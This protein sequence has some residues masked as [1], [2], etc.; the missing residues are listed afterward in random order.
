MFKRKLYIIR[1]V[2]KSM[3]WHNITHFII[4]WKQ[5]KYETI[6]YLRQTGVV[7]LQNRGSEMKC[8]TYEFRT[9]PMCAT[10]CLYKGH[11]G[12]ERGER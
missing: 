6:I 7:E 8:I 4:A 1:F 5:F 10:R 2:F 12:K 3:T 11:T 9:Q